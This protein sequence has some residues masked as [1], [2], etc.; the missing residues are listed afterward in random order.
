MANVELA[1]LDPSSVFKRPKDV[2]NDKT[3][4]RE[5]KI[6]ILRRWAYDERE[7][8]VAEEEN[9]MTP[10]SNGT[11][12]DEV[13]ESLLALGVDHEGSGAPTKQG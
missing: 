1:K 7:L 5:E 8:A 9:M 12:L 13:L 6:D 11:I 2:L 10:A 3:L 4:T